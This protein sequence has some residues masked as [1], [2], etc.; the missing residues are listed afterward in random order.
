VD[1]QLIGFVR[2]RKRKIIGYSH[3]MSINDKPLFE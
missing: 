1:L 2:G 3:F